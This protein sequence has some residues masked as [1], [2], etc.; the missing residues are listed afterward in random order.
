VKE[1][2]TLAPVINFATLWIK[3][4][5]KT[6]HM[7]TCVHP[8]LPAIVLLVH[9]AKTVPLLNADRVLTVRYQMKS[10]RLCACLDQ[11]QRALV[12]L[13]LVHVS[14]ALTDIALNTEIQTT[15]FTLFLTDFIAM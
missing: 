1:R 4:T 15:V 11:P 13:L 6:V 2:K 3:D 8:A 12:K 5:K 14:T 7:G 9:I 10:I